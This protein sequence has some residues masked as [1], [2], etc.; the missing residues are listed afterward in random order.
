MAKKA[1]TQE[2]LTDDERAAMKERAA[3]LKAAGKRGTG[4]TRRP[5]RTCRTA[6]PRSPRCRTPT[7]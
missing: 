1:A 3:E 6:W 4:A 2:K 7:A 5:R